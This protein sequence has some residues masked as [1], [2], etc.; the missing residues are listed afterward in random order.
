MQVR[1]F[2]IPLLLLVAGVAHAKDKRAVGLIS[3]EL[4]RFDRKVADGDLRNL[5]S[6]AWSLYQRFVDVSDEL[7]SDPGF[8]GLVQR[9]RASSSKAAA[10][11]GGHAK[12]I[13]GDGQVP[14]G[15][16]H[17]RAQL[18]SDVETACRAAANTS[19]TMTARDGKNLKDNYAKYEKALARAMKA[20]PTSLRHKNGHFKLF[21]CEWQV[22]QLQLD[23]EDNANMEESATESYKT[24]GYDEYVLR[25]L[26]MGGR[27]GAWEV[28]GV[29]GR[30]G[31]AL[32]CKK[33]PRAN[34]ISGNMAALFRSEFRYPSTAVWTVS[35]PATTAQVDLQTYQY[36]SVRVF[37]KD[38]TVQTNAC[39]DKDK[40]VVCEASGATLV[41][42]YNAAAHLS[43]RAELH[44][45]AGRAE[46]CKALYEK[47]RREA[48]DILE[49]YK[50]QSKRS[51]WDKTLKYKTRDDGVMTETK[52]IG[53]L[54]ELSEQADERS[55]GAYC[56][57]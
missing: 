16:D 2:V 22:A 8:P 17:E 6:D 24:C 18:F 11:A 51:D 35:G 10:A 26:K 14:E 31:F 52:L 27:W 30:N 47:A 13:L 4:D 20:D 55:V 29:P 3:E 40:K 21:Q 28:D 44:R 54:T 25:R 46:R 37:G 38:I 42:A 23:L 1:T 50:T 12:E 5:S 7:K 57:M 15:D 9:W 19:S 36:Q 49:Q 33:H 34:K 41:Q 39:G 32:D 48:A 43:A 56:K 45:A 53:K